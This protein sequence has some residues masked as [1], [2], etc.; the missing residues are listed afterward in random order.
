MKTMV[1]NWHNGEMAL[2]ARCGGIFSGC[3]GILF[4]LIL[5]NTFFTAFSLLADWLLKTT[6]TNNKKIKNQK[7]KKQQQKNA[8]VSDEG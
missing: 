7:N 6:T 8:S 2:G 1:K 3:V 5:L 4:L